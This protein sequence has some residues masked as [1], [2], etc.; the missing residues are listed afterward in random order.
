MAFDVGAPS[1]GFTPILNHGLFDIAEGATIFGE[2]AIPIRFQSFGR[3]HTSTSVGLARTSASASSDVSDPLPRLA[4]LHRET[5]RRSCRFGS[6]A[7]IPT[8]DCA[9]PCAAG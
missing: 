7:R 8:G 1:W 6:G 3:N 4:R 2:L 9:S 5:W